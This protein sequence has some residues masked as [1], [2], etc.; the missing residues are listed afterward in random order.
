MMEEYYATSVSINVTSTLKKL[1]K[2]QTC[3]GMDLNVS[4]LSKL[5]W[6]VSLQYTFHSKTS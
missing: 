5:L 6:I 2:N 1:K 3:L 4:G